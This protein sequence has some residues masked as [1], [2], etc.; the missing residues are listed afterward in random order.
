MADSREDII[1]RG[2][3]AFGEGD[4]ET[5]GS[6][7]TDDVVQTMP[8]KNLLA[9][10]HQGRDN[11]LGLYGKIFELSGGTF[12][13]E[14]KSVKTEGDK[15]VSVHHSQGER[16]G[17]TLSDDESIAFTFS[18]DKISRLDVTA[19]DQAAVDDFWT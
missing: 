4:M 15:V 8:G 9:G 18:G 12:K 13:V 10:E 14:L 3:R 6:L 17:K 16:G 1:R 11:V 5:L 19:G 7:Y 2:Y